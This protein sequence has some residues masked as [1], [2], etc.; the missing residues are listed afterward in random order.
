M[1][2]NKYDDPVFFEK[3]NQM[4]RSVQGLAGAGEWPTLKRLL[5]DFSGKSVLDL[6]CGLGW[7]AAYAMEHGAARVI[8]TDISEKMLKKAGRI[9]GR[10]GIEYRRAAFEDSEFEENSFDIVICSL[11]LHYLASYEEFLEKVHRWLKPQGILAYTV[12]HPVFTAEGKQDWY[13][14][15]DGKPL[16]FPVDRYFLEGKR[17]AVF[18]GEKVVKY[19]GTL[20]TYM[21]TL[22]QKGFRLLHTAEPM[23]TEEMVSKIPGMADELRRPMMLIVTAE[24]VR[25]EQ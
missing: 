24:K 6:G 8:A 2:E 14:D 9:N 19:H 23:P 20:T 13:Y 16:H 1:K 21:E 15:Q 10:E 25:S 4:T 3:Y 5:P 12:E 11:M 22:S 7:H 18:L 17:E